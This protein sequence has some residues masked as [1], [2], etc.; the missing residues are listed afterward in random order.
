MTAS[1]VQFE[2]AAEPQECCIFLR[3]RQNVILSAFAGSVGLTPPRPGGRGGTEGEGGLVPAQQD[4][5]YQ[6]GEVSSREAESFLP[7]WAN[8][9]VPASQQLRAGA[10]R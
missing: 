1:P 8:S 2:S 4:A 6:A 10:E 5:E 7:S 9:R 3:S